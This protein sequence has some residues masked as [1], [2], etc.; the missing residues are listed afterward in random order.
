MSTAFP[1]FGGPAASTEVPL[2]ML[3]A[4]HIRIER[5]CS[6]LRRLAGHLSDHGVDAQASL[7]AAQIMRYFD[8]AAIQ[9]HADE[10]QDLFPALIESMAGSDAICIRELTNGLIAD[11]RRLEAM[12]TQL[13]GTL[14]ELAR[15]NPASLPADTLEAFVSLYERHMKIEEEELIPMAQRLLGDA[16]I[17][18]I[19]LSMRKRRGIGDTSLDQTKG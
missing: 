14:V 2:E 16:A 10:E 12:W 15:G 3:A 6:T 11:H 19:G 8:T 9:H 13:R 17:T 1:G 7:A 5:Q 18:Q 4:C